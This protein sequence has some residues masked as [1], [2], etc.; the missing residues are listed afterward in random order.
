MRALAKAATP[1]VWQYFPLQPG[2][3]WTY[4][5]KI[6]SPSQQ[7]LL[8]RHIT[9]TV[10]SQPQPREYIAH[11][12]YQSGQ[13]VMPNVRY[14]HVPDGV[15]WAQLTGDTTYTGFAYLLKTPL[16]PGTT[17][18]TILNHWTQISATGLSCTV[19]AGTYHTC[20]ETR[21]DAEP[22]PNIRMITTRQ[23]APQ[24]GLVRQ[25]R[26]VFRDDVLQRLDTMLLQ[27]LTKSLR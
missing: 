25:Q 11:W 4:L 19:P 24:V 10:H 3:V 20:V 27:A 13:T 2:D 15:K 1:A 6:V 16:E 22:N 23:F 14:R 17:W 26:Q 21:V 5:E 18:R 8:E 9:L 7:V 12:D